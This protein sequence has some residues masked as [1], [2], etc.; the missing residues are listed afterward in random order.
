M[1]ALISAE[2]YQAASAL[3]V[4]ITVAQASNSKE[5][6][7]A[8]ASLSKLKPRG[9]LLAPIRSFIHGASNSPRQ[10]P[11]TCYP[12]FSMCANMR[13]PVGLSAMAPA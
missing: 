8:F 12:P 9:S 13:K 6:E 7:A 1:P 3:G 4:N 11:V 10:P 5:I 2:T